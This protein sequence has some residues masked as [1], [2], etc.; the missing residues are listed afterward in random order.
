M[1]ITATIELKITLEAPDGATA[2][3]LLLGAY[4]PGSRCDAAVEDNSAAVDYTI[5]SRHVRIWPKKRGRL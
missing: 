1:K 3:R 5:V 4:E 2:H